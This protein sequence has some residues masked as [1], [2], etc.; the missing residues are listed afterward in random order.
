MGM[1]WIVK[2]RR[3]RSGCTKLNKPKRK[4]SSCTVFAVALAAG[5]LVLAAAVPM[6]GQELGSL[7]DRLIRFQF[8]KNWSDTLQLLGIDMLIDMQRDALEAMIGRGDGGPGIRVAAIPG[9]ATGRLRLKKVKE[10]AV[11]KEI[12]NFSL[13]S[14]RSE[15]CLFGWSSGRDAN[16]RRRQVGFLY[17]LDQSR[18]LSWPDA[19]D[20]WCLM[21][22]GGLIGAAKPDRPYSLFLLNPGGSGKREVACPDRTFIRKM[23]PLASGRFLVFHF[24]FAAGTLFSIVDA[25]GKA[26]ERLY[27]ASSSPGAGLRE[28]FL[29]NFYQADFAAGKIFLAKVYPESGELDVEVIDLEKRSIRKMAASIPGFAG[30]KRNFKKYSAASIGVGTIA[31]VN[32][33]FAAKNGDRAYVS[34]SVND[35]TRQRQSFKHYLYRLDERE[36]FTAQ[37][38]IPFGCVLYYQRDK[39]IFV[40]QKEPLDEAAE[41]TGFVL[42]SAK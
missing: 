16:G 40:S 15:A 1:Y 26:V 36:A 39:E 4:N 32:G 27:P 12:S 13:F 2:T 34:L 25:G 8:A 31:A 41:Q 19:L 38:E 18:D 10:V 6:S 5:A 21:D 35:C 23:W 24:P 29:D 42:F 33:V 22:C 9:S 14:A 3:S 20:F 11:P 30:P 17:N 37:V 7:P 28:Y